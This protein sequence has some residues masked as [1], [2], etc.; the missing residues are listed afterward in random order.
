MIRAAFFN[1]ESIASGV[2]EILTVITPISCARTW[3]ATIKRPLRFRRSFRWLLSEFFFLSFFSSCKFNETIK[4]LIS[5]HLAPTCARPS[6]QLSAELFVTKTC[7]SRLTTLH[8]RFFSFTAWPLMSASRSSL[9]LTRKL[10]WAVC[11]RRFAT[12]SR[13]PSIGPR[14]FPTMR[15]STFRIAARRRWDFGATKRRTMLVNCSGTLIRSYHF[16]ISTQNKFLTNYFPK[17]VTFKRYF[18]CF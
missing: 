2:R 12:Q 7:H 14:S 15:W 17:R 16:L 13:R 11:R 8:K 4:M 9:T 3:S 1:H 18:C 6:I 10:T 5:F